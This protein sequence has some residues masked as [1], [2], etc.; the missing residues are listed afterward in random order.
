MVNQGFHIFDKDTKVDNVNNE[1]FLNFNK[2]THNL[3]N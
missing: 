1:E 2:K 3:N